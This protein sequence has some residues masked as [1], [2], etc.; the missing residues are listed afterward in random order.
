MSVLEKSHNGAVLGKK[1][2]SHKGAAC[3]FWRNVIMVR[4]RERRR[5][6]IKVLHVRSGEK[7]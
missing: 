3:L 5:N 4:F 2:K 1:E 7:S 6:V